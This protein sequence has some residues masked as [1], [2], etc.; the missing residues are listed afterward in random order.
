MRPDASDLSAGG[1]RIVAEQRGKETR[2][3]SASSLVGALWPTVVRLDQVNIIVSDL[4][5]YQF[6][7]LGV[8][9]PQPLENKRKTFHA[10][11]KPK[12]ELAELIA[13]VLCRSGCGLAQPICRSDCLGFRLATFQRKIAAGGADVGIAALRKTAGRTDLRL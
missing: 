5:R 11:S 6:Y 10:R 7:R 13:R 2:A 3:A 1:T 12:V 9:F 8:S 4:R